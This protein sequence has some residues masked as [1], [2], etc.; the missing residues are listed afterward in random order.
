MKDFADTF[1][2]YPVKKTETTVK[3]DPSFGGYYVIHPTFYMDEE[4]LPILNEKTLKIR[5]EDYVSDFFGV[6][7]IVTNIVFLPFN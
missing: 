3:Y 5:L 2:R 7:A 6:E 1:N 4:Y